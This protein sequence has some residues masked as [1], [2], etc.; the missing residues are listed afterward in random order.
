MGRG[1]RLTARHRIVEHD[2]HKTPVRVLTPER[3]IQHQ[4]VPAVPIEVPGLGSPSPGQGG[5]E[6]R[7]P[8]AHIPNSG[9]VL[10]HDGHPVVVQN[11]RVKQGPSPTPEPA[12]RGLEG[13][14]SLIQV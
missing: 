7:I 10:G 14:V 6:G 4:V 13:A 5:G 3:P 12:P 8:P 11:N 9:L 2:P 1:Q